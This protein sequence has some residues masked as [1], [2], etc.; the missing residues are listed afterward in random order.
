MEKFFVLEYNP[1]RNEEYVIN[2]DAIV[3]INSNNTIELT[4]GK[5]IRITPEEKEELLKR[6]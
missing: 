2:P 5:T 6:V 1:F 3:C 4:N